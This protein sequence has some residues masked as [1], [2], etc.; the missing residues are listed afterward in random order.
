MNPK[1]PRTGERRMPCPA[2]P[3]PFLKK[4]QNCDTSKWNLSTLLCPL[5]PCAL[6]PAAMPVPLPCALPC[7]AWPCPWALALAQSC[8]NVIFE[9]F[10]ALNLATL[11]CPLCPAPAPCALHPACA[12]PALPCLPWPCPSG[13]L[14]SFPQTL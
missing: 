2:A 4:L 14:C 3:S 10:G 5:C 8:K 12:L 13:Q 9:V 6:C 1:T 11:P 7:P